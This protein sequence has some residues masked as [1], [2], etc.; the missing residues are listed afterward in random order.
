MLE[1][2]AWRSFCVVTLLYA[3]AI[4]GYF[5]FARAANLVLNNYILNF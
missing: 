4:T 1:F 2:Y 5:K 3:I